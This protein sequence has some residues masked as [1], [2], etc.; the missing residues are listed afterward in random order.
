M[1]CQSLNSISDSY[2]SLSFLEQSQSKWPCNRGKDNRS[3]LIETTKR[4]LRPFNRGGR[5]TGIL[6]TVC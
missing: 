4:W 1:F 5:L 3:T 6:F 2:L